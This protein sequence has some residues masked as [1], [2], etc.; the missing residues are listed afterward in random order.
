MVDIG[1]SNKENYFITFE[2]KSVEPIAVVKKYAGIGATI[3][4]HIKNTRTN[5]SIDF[6]VGDVAEQ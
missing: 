5:L 1:A 3:V 4:A 2:V 6:W